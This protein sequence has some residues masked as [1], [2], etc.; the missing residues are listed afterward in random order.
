MALTDSADDAMACTPE[1]DIII[2][3]I[4]VTVDMLRR[5]HFSKNTPLW[6][7]RLDIRVFRCSGF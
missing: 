4:G 2:I 1:A 7:L 5:R 6:Y 3:N